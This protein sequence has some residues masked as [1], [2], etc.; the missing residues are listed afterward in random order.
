MPATVNLPLPTVLLVGDVGARMEL[1]FVACG[2][3]TSFAPTAAEAVT[4]MQVHAHPFVVVPARLPDMLG[5]DFAR[6]LLLHFERTGV[7]L[8]GDDVD[9]N[10]VLQLARTSRLVHIPGTV[11]ASS[12]V[13]FLL[14]AQGRPARD[15]PR[16]ATSGPL[17]FSS[18][19]GLGTM[20]STSL[21]P[22]AAAVAAL[23]TPSASL[24]QLE[25]LQAQLDSITQARDHAEQELAFM[26]M[27][28]E[29]ARDDAQ[30]GLEELTRVQAEL[31]A[32]Q[33]LRDT[34]NV[35]VEGERSTWLAEREQL[36]A[37]LAV[38]Q[39]AHASVHGTLAHVESELAQVRD[40]MRALVD[41]RDQHARLAAAAHEEAR[42]EREARAQLEAHAHSEI[43]RVSKDA[44]SALA[45]AAAA[46]A[47]LQDAIARINALADAL[48]LAQ[49]QTNQA[50]LGK[51]G[52]VDANVSARM[53]ELSDLVRALEPFLWGLGRATTFLEA[54]HVPGSD[55]HLRT[56]RLLA[57]TLERLSEQVPHLDK[58][59]R[60]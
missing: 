51:N 3:T 13:D 53:A 54:A 17:T 46:R 30:Q 47:D 58:L 6:V 12:V 40:G 55:D 35:E 8:Y 60:A 2:V 23:P 44:E 1:D 32:V 39:R 48:A 38:E 56:L 4:K 26:R 29:E 33:L 22:T 5:T 52:S 15:A 11:P 24:G 49:A 18:I 16:P 21:A 43:E 50:T 41:D 28:Y 20:R 25:A 7:V 19:D 27:A 10:T 57:R 42:R 9:P 36:S 37:Q 31:G 34:R 45:E 14:R 59:A